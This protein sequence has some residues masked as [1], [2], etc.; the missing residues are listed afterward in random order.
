MELSQDDNNSQE[1]LKHNLKRE[2]NPEKNKKDKK[3][4]KHKHDKSNKDLLNLTEA[5][6]NE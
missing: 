6:I 3:H 5:E 4:K 2:D 1:D